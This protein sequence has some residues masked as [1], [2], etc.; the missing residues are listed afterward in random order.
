ME[1]KYPGALGGGRVGCLFRQRPPGP[2][3]APA[4]SPPGKCPFLQGPCFWS[5]FPEP[6]SGL[7]DRSGKLLVLPLFH[8]LTFLTNTRTLL[9]LFPLST[10][11]I[12]T[13]KKLMRFTSARLF[14]T[15]SFKP[16]VT[17]LDFATS[18][19]K[20]SRRSVFRFRPEN[21][22]QILKS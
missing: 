13:F 12:E 22:M 20:T 6:G 4:Q 10:D 1:A 2:S 8:S 15:P 16:L 9:T 17:L 14:S 19:R 7:S 11:T 3:L 18:K 5:G 21:E